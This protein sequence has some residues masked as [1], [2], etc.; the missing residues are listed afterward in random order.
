MNYHKAQNFLGNEKNLLKSIYFSA[1]VYNIY[2]HH[3][4]KTVKWSHL[5]YLGT[6][7]RAAIIQV[8]VMTPILFHVNIS[9]E[10]NV[11]GVLLSTIV[12]NLNVDINPW[13]G[14]VQ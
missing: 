8:F 12:P 3:S 7:E 13:L 10:M 11:P 9:N 4:P 2:S 1:V 14:D 6:G 5:S